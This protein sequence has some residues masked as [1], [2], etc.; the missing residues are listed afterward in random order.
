[1]K[2]KLSKETLI[3]RCTTAIKSITFLKKI[4]K[5]KEMFKK[6]YIE[7]QRYSL[8]EGHRNKKPGSKIWHYMAP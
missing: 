8:I 7:D 6:R 4:H 5:H 2:T 1:M 3:Y